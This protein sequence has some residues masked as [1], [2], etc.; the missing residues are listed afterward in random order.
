MPKT[1]DGSW[2]AGMAM[3]VRV[4][5]TRAARAQLRIAHDAQHARQIRLQHI[6]NNHQN[7][8]ANDSQMIMQY[9]PNPARGRHVPVR[10]ITHGA[11]GQSQSNRRQP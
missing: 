1:P 11:H 4:D 9:P 10:R 6:D 5:V 3:L 8:T 7:A 2:P